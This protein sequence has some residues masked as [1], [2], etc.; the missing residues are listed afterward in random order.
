[1][2]RILFDKRDYLLL[3]IVNDV[4]S[5]DKSREYTRRLVYSY[6]HPHGVKELA[7]SK[8]LRLAFAVI[9]L[10]QS[11]EAGGVDARLSAL[12][13]LHSEVLHIGGGSLPINTAR[14]LLQIMKELIRAHGD[15]ERQLQLAHDFRRSVTGNPR[16][17]RA[18][19][20]NYH[21]LE[22]PE[23]WNQVTFDDHVHDANTKGRKS[24]SHLIMD[25]W[26]KGIRRLRV[27][28]YNYLEPRFAVE[29][30]EAARIMGIDIRT[31]IEFSSRFRGK[32]VHLIWVPRGFVDSQDFLCF[33]A[34]DPVVEFMAEGRRVS[35]YQ[36]AYVY[37]IFDEFNSRHRLTVRETH[38]LEIPP[39]NI[40]DFISFVGTGQASLL[41]LAEF[42]HKN[43][44]PLMNSY[45]EELRNLYA[46]AANEERQRIADKV[47][48]LNRLDAET[49]LE[50]YLQPEKNP[51]I[52]DPN[53][54]GD[55]SNVPAL[56][57]LSPKGLIDRLV[58][59]HSGQ[60]FTLN[61]SN[62]KVEDV[63]ELLYDCEGIITRL[64]IF[65]LKDH[66]NK[67]TDHIP[68]I[69]RL[70]EA[71]NRKN[72]IHLKKIIREV[73]SK[74]ESSGLEDSGDRIKKLAYILNDISTLR[75]MYL[76][77]QLK[78][79][80]GSDSTG[81]SIRFH[82]MGLAIMDTLPRRAVKEVHNPGAAV[83]E[84]IPIKV[85]AFRRKT[86]F[87]RTSPNKSVAR[88]YRLAEKIPA[89]QLVSQKQSA[90]WLIGQ[91]E[92]V[93][94]CG[95]VVTLGGI[96]KHMDNGLSIDPPRAEKRKAGLSLSYLNTG[97]KNG[98]KV[99]IGFIPAFFT[100]ALTKDWWLLAYFGA[101]IWFGITGL[102]NILQSVMGGGGIKRAP[103][104]RWN[105]YV[106]WERLTDSLL[107]TGFS[108]PLLDYVTK[109]VVLD[110]CFN[111][112]TA[113]NPIAL[114]AFMALV[115]GLY[116]S[117]HNAFRG[118][119]KGAI[120]GNL[121]RSILS[122]PVAVLLNAAIGG[123]L[124]SS[125]VTHVSD[126]LQKWA[127]VISKASSDFVAGIIEGTADRYQNIRIRLRDYSEKLEQLF[128]TYSKLEMFFPEVNTMELLKN[129][130]KIT[131]ATNE[132]VRDLE[133]ILIIHALDLLYFWMYQPR[134]RSAL[135]SLVQSLSDEEREILIGTQSVLVQQRKISLLFV[136]G[137]VG[138]NFS[139][140][141]SFYLDRSQEYMA[142]MDQF[143]IPKQ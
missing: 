75:D 44:L 83:R 43:M 46:N 140:A 97:T 84:H 77:A 71:L 22:M 32:Y 110:R 128:D 54:P 2:Q 24:S 21:L 87:R 68:D 95:N 122:I 51:G 100:F 130:T 36:T 59:L 76:G 137:L 131:Q 99:L 142:D 91:S 90:D 107:F 57:K 124:G 30:L 102:R 134:A 116:I 117:S 115:N 31:G 28:Y 42:L 12:R 18:Q 111:I 6:L 40:S 81:R 125:G 101:F 16:I 3:N 1:M 93:K 108:V 10:F 114:Y 52:P 138:K 33:L 25:A 14:V 60:R 98:L 119:P 37:K 5:R 50:Q 65:N 13:S 7:E 85:A 88:L 63:I 92:Y 20:R 4:L 79:R 74:L 129:P 126:V 41:H 113:T 69:S 72:V 123:I 96:Q 23:E 135:R 118:L 103:M 89:L 11:L 105:D 62:L 143:S 48:E 94:G 55:D 67:K 27:I 8:G 136:D 127:A 133:K 132:E 141:L 64:E 121:F 106:S 49:I 26:I 82:G 109:T 70:Q 56:L 34:E 15:T 58:Q 104:L 29:L 39:L 47:A 120:I 9:H 80:I 19:L 86:S 45:V 139:K 66:A 73:I 53:F 61:L 38:G 35:E 78:S 17:I 112:T